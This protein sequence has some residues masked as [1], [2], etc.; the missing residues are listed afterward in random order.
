MPSPDDLIRRL[1]SMP[2]EFRAL[3][4]RLDANA[5]TAP[6]DDGWSPRQ[7]IE[8]VRASD[9]I[10]AP[11]IYHVLVRD[12][13]PLTAFDDRKWGSLIAAAEVPID[14]QLAA[15]AITRAE[16]CAMLRTLQPED[17]TRT[18]VHEE[19]GKI[20]LTDIAT[21]L[22]AH[23]EEHIAQLRQITHDAPR[24]L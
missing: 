12:D 13:A 4:R 15:F 6:Y 5:L 2:A 19:R 3:I 1:Q 10:I 16:L 18:G 24:A 23:E 7:I 22:A 9:A 14:A 17:W 21:W 20:T 8:H 11:R